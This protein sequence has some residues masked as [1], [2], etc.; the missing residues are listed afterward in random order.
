MEPDAAARPSVPPIAEAA[1]ST[2]E[3]AAAAVVDQLRSREWEL[4]P[5]E[6]NTPQC[7]WATYRHPLTRCASYRGHD[8]THALACGLPVRVL[9]AG[10]VFTPCEMPGGHSGGCCY[11]E[12]TQL[13]RQTQISRPVAT[14]MSLL[15]P[16]ADRA[17]DLRPAAAYGGVLVD[18]EGNVTG[19]CSDHDVAVGIVEACVGLGLL[20]AIAAAAGDRLVELA[21]GSVMLTA[22]QARL[23]EELTR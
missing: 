13:W 18:G 15:R 7:P 16:R 20:E 10:R 17:A 3:G 5:F 2:P 22:G 23:L 19:M 6:F 12:E 14:V 9:A 21:A 1:A 11:G 8:D 4:R